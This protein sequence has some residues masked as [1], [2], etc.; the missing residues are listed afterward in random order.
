MHYQQGSLGRVFLVKLEHGDDLLKEINHLAAETGLKSAC[1]FMIGALDKAVMVTGP[2]QS[3]LPPQVI[4]KRIDEGREI[5]AIGTM[6]PDQDSGEPVLHI[7]GSLGRG[8]TTFTGCL[9]SDSRVFAVVELLVV[10]LSGFTASKGF[11]LAILMKTLI[12]NRTD[13]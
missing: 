12:M 3:A 1:L 4:E 9:R 10:E 2:Q 13:C 11:D 8:D 6:F 7:H 5:V